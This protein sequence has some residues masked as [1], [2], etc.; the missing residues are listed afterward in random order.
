MLLHERFN[1]EDAAD[2][3]NQALAIDPKNA[4]A[5][6][7]LAEVSAEGFDDKATEYIARRRLR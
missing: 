3:F 7:G 4:L 1:N 2:L 6:L 5:Y